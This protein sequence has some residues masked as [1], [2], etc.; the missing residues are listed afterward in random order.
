MTSQPAGSTGFGIGR[1]SGP[2]R[3]H[4]IVASGYLASTATD[5]S[6]YLAMYLR[7]GTAEDGTRIV[8]SERCATFSHRA[9]RA[10]R[11]MGRRRRRPLR[12]G[13]AGRRPVGRDGGLPPG[14]HPRL[15]AMLAIFPDRGLAVASL[16]PAGH[17]LPCRRTVTAGPRVEQPPARCARPAVHDVPSLTRFYLL[18]DGAALLLLAERLVAD[19]RGP[20]ASTGRTAASPCRRAG[21][22]A[23]SRCRRGSTRVAADLRLGRPCGCGHPI[24][25]G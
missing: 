22:G 11:S 4:G 8:S 13:L 2:V 20:V 3:R 16:V 25:P 21:P 14:E 7:G 6:R 17:E 1:S 9:R 10:P 18:F 19:T 5:L 12:D 24:S 23:A 15:S